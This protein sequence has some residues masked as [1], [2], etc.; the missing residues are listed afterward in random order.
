[1]Q[2]LTA[3]IRASMQT[4]TILILLAVAG[5]L[6]AIL[7]GRERARAR[8]HAGAALSD[9]DRGLAVEACYEGLRCVGYSCVQDC[10]NPA[11]AAEAGAAY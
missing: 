11:V 10:E 7:R 3:P 4:T 8:T 9:R 2:S 6:I 5:A 1:M